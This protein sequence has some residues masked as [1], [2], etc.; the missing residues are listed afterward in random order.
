MQGCCFTHAVS[1]Q[2]VTN[3]REQYLTRYNA[4]STGDAADEEDDDSLVVRSFTDDPDIPLQQIK[5]STMYMYMFMCCACTCSVRVHTEHTCTCMFM[6]VYMY[7][8]H[9]FMVLMYIY[10]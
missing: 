2:T 8:V 3:F 7:I 10:I 9:V 6:Y 4:N 5:V 1:L